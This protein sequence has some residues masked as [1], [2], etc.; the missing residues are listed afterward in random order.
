MRIALF[1]T[2]S[3]VLLSG[4]TKSCQ[5]Q[6][7]KEDVP[8]AGIAGSRHVTVSPE[9]QALAEAKKNRRVLKG[10]VV[11]AI[12]KEGFAYIRLETP[13]ETSWVAI[14]KQKP[15]VGDVIAV[16]EQ[17]VLTDFH[18]KSLDKTFPKIIFGAIVD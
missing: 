5:E 4:C 7:P 14:V 6:K 17:A 12:Y 16:Q 3:L 18:S 1:V 8:P 15:V 9:E 13:S 11:E 2:L 10:K